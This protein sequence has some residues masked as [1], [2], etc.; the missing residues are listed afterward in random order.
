MS[1]HLAVTSNRHHHQCQCAHL[2]AV[3]RVVPVSSRCG[4]YNPGNQ[5]MTQLHLRSDSEWLADGGGACSL[6]STSTPYGV[7]EVRYLRPGQGLLQ[8]SRLTVVKGLGL[9]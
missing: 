2:P 1:G 7:P 4:C 8:G 5:P 9:D 6:K 3:Q